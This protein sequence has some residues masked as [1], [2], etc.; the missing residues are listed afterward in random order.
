MNRSQCFCP[1]A[2]ISI[3]KVFFYV[4]NTPYR[5]SSISFR[6]ALLVRLLQDPANQ[7]QANFEQEIELDYTDV[8]I[9]CSKKHWFKIRKRAEVD[10]ERV[11]YGHVVK[12]G[13]NER[14]YPARVS[15]LQ[16]LYLQ[17]QEPVG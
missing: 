2:S 6:S 16:S 13:P 7:N 10:V 14:T 15:G 12:P 17:K 11:P 5:V 8:R 4:S 1:S 3:Y 9:L